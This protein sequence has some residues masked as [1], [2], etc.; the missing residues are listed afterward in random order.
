MQS[1]IALAVGVF[2]AIPVAYVSYQ[3]VERPFLRRR[4][5]MIAQDAPTAGISVVIAQPGA[6]G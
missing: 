2:V 6:G 4:H 3:L 5:H 1:I